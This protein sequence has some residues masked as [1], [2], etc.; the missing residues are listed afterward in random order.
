MKYIFL[1]LVIVAIS[2]NLIQEET[3]FIQDIFDLCKELILKAARPFCINNRPHGC[4]PA[5]S[6]FIYKDNGEVKLK[7]PPLSFIWELVKIL[8][9]PSVAY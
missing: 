8:F 7:F 4:P 3:N 1:A 6:A 9:E 5:I 2:C